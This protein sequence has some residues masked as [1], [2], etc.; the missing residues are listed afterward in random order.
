MFPALEVPFQLF[1]RIRLQRCRELVPTRDQVPLF[2]TGEMRWNHQP[3]LPLSESAQEWAMALEEPS[4][5]ERIPPSHEV[6]K[7]RSAPVRMTSNREPVSEIP[8]RDSFGPAKYDARHLLLSKA[9]VRFEIGQLV[10]LRCEP[11]KIRLSENSVEDHQ[12]F[13]CASDWRGPPQAAVRLA[14]RSVEGLVLKVV[15]VSA[16]ARAGAGR[17]ELPLHQ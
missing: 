9:R 14:N 5:V 17:G 13:N 4:E 8:N 1:Q 15:Q 7:D 16:S 12:A 3:D 10:A 11:H 2:G 6:Q